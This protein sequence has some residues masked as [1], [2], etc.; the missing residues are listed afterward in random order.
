MILVGIF[1]Y[2]DSSRNIHIRTMILVGIFTCT[3]M[4]SVD[5]ISVNTL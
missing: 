1:T 5:T 3:N 4:G 2:Y